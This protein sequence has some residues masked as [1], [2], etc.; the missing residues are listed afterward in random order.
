MQFGTARDGNVGHSTYETQFRKGKAF[1]IHV[2][3][4]L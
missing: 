2:A 1:A 4:Y 3:I